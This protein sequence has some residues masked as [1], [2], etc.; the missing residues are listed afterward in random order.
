MALNP[1]TYLECGE[2]LQCTTLIMNVIVLVLGVLLFGL[3]GNPNLFVFVVC[4]LSLFQLV[5]RS[6]GKMGLVYV[7]PSSP[8]IANSICL[9]RV[10]STKLVNASISLLPKD[11]PSLMNVFNE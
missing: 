1:S 8:L 5:P 4:G 11:P 7:L 9:V 3:R 10:K 2:D 6:L